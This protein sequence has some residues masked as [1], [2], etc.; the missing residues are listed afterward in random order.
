[1]KA[2]G[3]PPLIFCQDA[4]IKNCLLLNLEEICICNVRNLF[5]GQVKM[6]QMKFN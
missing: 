6:I 4:V 1:M 5:A 3:D 2:L